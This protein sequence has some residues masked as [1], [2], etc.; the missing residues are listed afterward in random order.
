MKIPCENCIVL[1]RCKARIYESKE[2]II[3]NKVIQ[4]ALNE[5]LVIFHLCGEC[6]KLEEYFSQ[7]FEKTY[8]DGSFHD[9]NIW[10]IITQS[11]HYAQLLYYLKGNEFMNIPCENCITLASCLFR[12]QYVE[13]EISDA[14]N[15]VYDLSHCDLI[16]EYIKDN[17]YANITN[18]FVYLKPYKGSKSKVI[19]SSS[20]IER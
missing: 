18:F 19:S 5:Q 3:G 10:K 14:V 8:E 13:S 7:I 1:P 9:S 16:K 2:Y 20:I 15:I 12:F 11:P 6:Y 17:G 4:K